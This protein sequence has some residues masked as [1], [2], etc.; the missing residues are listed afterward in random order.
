M[1]LI[2]SSPATYFL[3]LFPILLSQKQGAVDPKRNRAFTAIERHTLCR[4]DNGTYPSRA[5]RTK[6]YL[7]ILNFEPDRFPT[8]GPDFVSSN[9]TYHGDVD[10]GITKEFMVMEANQKKYPKEYQL[11]FGKRPK[12]ELYRI[13]SD[14]NQTNNLANDKSYAKIK[15]ELAY[16]LTKYL[17]ETGDPRVR[18][19][20]PWQKYAYLK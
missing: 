12:E 7:Y 3:L 13:A 6:D 16:A 19:E 11:S 20:D 1:S 8:G 14:K 2:L 17:L 18:G 4:P 5:I 15:N 10:A 9:N